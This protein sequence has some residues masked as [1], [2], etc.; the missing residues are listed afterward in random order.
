LCGCLLVSVAFEL[1]EGI[2]SFGKGGEREYQYPYNANKC[3]RSST[4]N[5]GGKGKGDH[6]PRVRYCGGVKVKRKKKV[7]IQGQPQ[8]KLQAKLPIQEVGGSAKGGVLN[9]LRSESA[10]KNSKRLPKDVSSSGFSFQ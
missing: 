7:E 8:K 1:E 10:A 6:S 5:N 4:P 2:S 3:P 9:S